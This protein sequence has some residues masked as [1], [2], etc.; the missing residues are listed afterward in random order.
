[1]LAS[2]L[3][4]TETAAQHLV[5]RV[6]FAFA[7]DTV[8]TTL[9]SLPG[10]RFDSVEAVYIVDRQG[11][12]CGLVRLL[13]LLRTPRDLKLGEVMTSQTP[14]ASLNDDQ[15]RVAGLAVE[16]GLTDV[17]V[18]DRQGC[19][20]GV[21]PARA[22][23][24]ILRREHIEDLDRLTGIKRENSHAHHAL[25]APPLQRTRDR[26]PWLLVGLGGSILATFVVSRFERTL[27]QKVFVGFFV[28]G[29]AYLADAI[30]TQTEAI[31]VRGLS[32][33]QNSLRNLLTGEIWT[34]F[35]IGLCL[36]TISFPI[37]L[38]GFGNL[39]LAFTVAFTILMA[40]GVA[41]SVGLL[42]PWLLYRAGKDPAYGSGP[43]A[44]IIQDVLSLLIYFAIVKFL[45]V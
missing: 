9:G 36:G 41:T 33:S 22:L 38:A 21:V 5:V 13:D 44:T 30:G 40:G 37:V 31:V 6:P 11:H 15:E 19:L 17:P 10:N 27:E 14:T 18:V 28:P 39:R 25:E 7:E 2:R 23:I 34:G 16:H 26:L 8:G 20:L 24:A 1:M 12:L 35:L 43:V 3:T 42:F 45:Q 4:V 32:M 29:I